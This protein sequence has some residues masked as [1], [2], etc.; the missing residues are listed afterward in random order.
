MVVSEPPSVNRVDLSATMQSQ[1]AIMDEFNKFKEEIASMVKNKL[2]IDTDNS[3]L[4][5]K[6]YKLSGG[7]GAWGQRHRSPS[8][9]RAPISLNSLSSPSLS[10]PL[11]SICY[12]KEIWLEMAAQ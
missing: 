11:L 6:P 8:R 12:R 3:R 4:Y 9:Q 10:L 7:A 1:L 5:Q 2:G